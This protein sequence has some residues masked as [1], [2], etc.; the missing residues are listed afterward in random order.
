MEVS[1]ILNNKTYNNNNKKSKCKCNNKKIKKINNNNFN[2]N[3][4]NKKKIS[5][6]I[7]ITQQISNPHNLFKNPDPTKN[8]N[9]NKINPKI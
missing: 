2:K 7:T 1:P 4:N 9:K 6:I 8:P 5:N 3:N